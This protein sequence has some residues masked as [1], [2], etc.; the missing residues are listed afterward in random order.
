MSQNNAL[1]AC[2]TLAFSFLFHSILFYFM[3]LFYFSYEKNCYLGP[4]KSV[5][6]KV[7]FSNLA[8]H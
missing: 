8:V 1:T 6:L 5:F 3:S 4:S 7:G 2:E